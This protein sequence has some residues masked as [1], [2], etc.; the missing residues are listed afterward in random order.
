V[1][2][3]SHVR[4]GGDH[5]LRAA[6][7]IDDREAPVHERDVNDRAIRA[8]RAITESSTSVGAAVCNVRIE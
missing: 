4:R 1:R 8:A 6:I 5:R 3:A 7:A 2:A